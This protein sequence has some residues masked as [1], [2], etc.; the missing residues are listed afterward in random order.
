MKKYDWYNTPINSQCNLGKEKGI[1]Y[2]LPST[3]MFKGSIPSVVR[4]VAPCVA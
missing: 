3:R 1:D 4:L 2:K